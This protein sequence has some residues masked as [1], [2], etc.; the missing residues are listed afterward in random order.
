MTKAG[1]RFADV[2]ENGKLK[3]RSTADSMSGV[4]GSKKYLAAMAGAIPVV[5]NAATVADATYRLNN[6]YREDQF[7]ENF[8][9]ELG[10]NNAPFSGQSFERESAIISGEISA[11]EAGG[12]GGAGLGLYC[13]YGAIVC[14]PVGAIALGFGG[15]RLGGWTAKKLYDHYSGLS[16]Q[17][18]MKVRKDI[19]DQM[20]NNPIV[21][22]ITREKEGL[23]E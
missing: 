11:G 7:Y 19:L 1:V 20:E 16:E 17:E 9:R 6:E 2:D 23:E 15:D 18:Q 5:G 13:G 10:V 3:A 8:M 4:R 14:S 22:T 12:W 21:P